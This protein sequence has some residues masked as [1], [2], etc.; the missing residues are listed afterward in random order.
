M[1]KRKYKTSFSQLTFSAA[2]CIIIFFPEDN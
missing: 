1:S 2:N